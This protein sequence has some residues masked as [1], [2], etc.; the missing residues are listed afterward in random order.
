MKRLSLPLHSHL[1]H[2]NQHTHMSKPFESNSLKIRITTSVLFLLGAAGCAAA[3]LL[4]GQDAS[5]D[6]ATET[7]EAVGKLLPQQDDTVLQQSRVAVNLHAKYKLLSMTI[8]FND[9]F[10]DGIDVTQQVTH[11]SGINLWQFTPGKDKL[12][13]A[14]SAGNNC[15]TVTYALIARS[16]VTHSIDWCFKAL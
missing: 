13:T 8:Y 15:V 4:N 1:E 2:T 3:V 14:L 16:D 7:N 12:I 5:T 9:K 11:E 6:L 10:V